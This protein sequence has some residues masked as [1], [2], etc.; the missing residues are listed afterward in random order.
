MKFTTAAFAFAAITSYAGAVE[1]NNDNWDELTAGKTVFI[2]FFA[3]WCGHCKKM[4]PDWDALMETY[5]DNE[6]ILVADVDCTS[7]GGKDLCSTAGVKGYPTIKHGDPSNLQDYQGGRDKD[8]IVEFASKLKPLC[9]P[10]NLD[11]CEEEDKKKIEEITAMDNGDIEKV[12]KEGEQK[13]TDADE[14]FNSEVQKLQN[15]YQKLQEDKE[16]TVQEINDSGIGMYKA[17]LAHKKKNPASEEK[18]E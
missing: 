15:A 9:S 7:D 10:A 18:D 16:K 2:K 6:K 11:L 4:K 1:L 8:A 14:L 12:I 17:V 13:I 5:A 3:P